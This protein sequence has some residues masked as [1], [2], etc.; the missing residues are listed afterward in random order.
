[1]RKDGASVNLLVRRLSV[2]RRVEDVA[3]LFFTDARGHLFAP[4]GLRDSWDAVLEG[5]LV[6]IHDDDASLVHE[7]GD[8]PRAV[9]HLFTRQRAG[10]DG[11]L[12]GRLGDT[13]ALENARELHGRVDELIHL[14]DA[15]WIVGGSG[16]RGRW[17]RDAGHRDFGFSEGNAACARGAMGA[18]GVR[19]APSRRR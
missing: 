1:V 15:L 6:R 2:V 3:A 13:L 17:V 19:G 14:A 7:L 16:R 11:D 18:R 4:D 10:S 12:E 8:R 5:I 9:G